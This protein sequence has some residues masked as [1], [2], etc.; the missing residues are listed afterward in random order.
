LKQR[1]NGKEK[2]SLEETEEQR[3]IRLKE[4]REL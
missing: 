2:R 4:N 1:C 3:Q